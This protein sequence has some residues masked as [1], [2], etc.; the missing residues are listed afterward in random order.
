MMKSQEK[1]LP[2]ASFEFIASIFQCLTLLTRISV[3]WQC[4][5]QM[6]EMKEILVK[7]LNQEAHFQARDEVG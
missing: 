2:K 6:A 5:S 1:C 4:F 7:Q 3:F